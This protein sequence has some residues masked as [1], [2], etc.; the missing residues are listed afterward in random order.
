MKWTTALGWL[1]ALLASAPCQAARTGAEP[2]IDPV[3]SPWHPQA[4]A[5]E[6]PLWPDALAIAP[7]ATTGAERFGRSPGTVAGQPV[8]MVQRVSRPSMSIYRPSVANSGAAIVVFP[9]GGYRVLAIDL[10]GTE[11]C[12]WL[13]G[14]GITC[15]LLKYRVP[16]SGPYWADECNCRRIPDVPMAL[17]DAQRAIA[18]LRDQAHDLGIDPHRV[19]VIGFSAGGRMVADVSNAP[20]RSYDAVDAADQQATRPDFALALYP[21]H[22]WDK[23]K[24]GLTLDAGVQIAADSPPTFI[25]QAGDD[26]TDDVRHSMTYYLALQQ[27]GIPAELH[28][29]P[30]GGHAFGL[31][32]SN[33]P[34]AE[35][36]SLARA[37]LHEIGVLSDSA[38]VPAE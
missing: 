19:G 35:W 27:A 38:I 1:F 4:P 22:L 14:Q 2:L 36:P 10:E 24:P 37:W 33:T 16:G 25:L 20:A 13:V 34:L 5:I 31:R 30:D 17:Q 8:T 3:D 21:G 9:G 6:Q 32:V 7:P 15:V 26:P 29:Y 28:L 23:D 12:D 18:L 11:V